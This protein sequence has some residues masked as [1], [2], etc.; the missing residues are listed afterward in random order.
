MSNCGV[1]GRGGTDTFVLTAV[2]RTQSITIR[3]GSYSG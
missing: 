2:V 3:N 1:G